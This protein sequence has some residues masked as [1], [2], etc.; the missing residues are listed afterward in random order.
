LSSLAKPKQKALA[1]FKKLRILRLAQPPLDVDDSSVENPPRE[2]QWR[3]HNF[4]E[5]YFQ[6]LA[7]EGSPI[8]LLALSPTIGTPKYI[9]HQDAVGHTFPHYYY[10]RGHS[11]IQLPNNQKVEQVVAHPVPK[12]E[13]GRYLDNFKVLTDPQADPGKPAWAR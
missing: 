6:Y 10:L 1:L 7:K 3:A 5:K 2:R 4:A 12:S 8:K 11:T 9:Y 13:I